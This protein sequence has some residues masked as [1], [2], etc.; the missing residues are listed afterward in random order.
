MK[1]KIGF[2]ICMI[3][4]V[5]SILYGITIWAAQSGTAFFMIWFV[6]AAL[7][8]II[9][10]AF[11]LGWIYVIK[12]FLPRQVR[13]SV[14]VIFL[15]LLGLF[16]SVEG[17][18][19]SHFDDHT[20]ENLDYLIVL[21]AK[22]DEHGPALS[23]RYRL[24]AASSYL[25]EHPYTVCILS[26]G[27]G[28]NEP[29]AEAVVMKEYLMNKGIEDSRM[30]VENQSLN[31]IGNIKNSWH[32]IETR[33]LVSGPQWKKEECKTGIVTN[34]FHL[35]RATQIGK[36]QMKGKIYGIAAP[37]PRGYLTNN[38]V[39]EFFGVVKDTLKNNM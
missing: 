15:L 35:Y 24:D 23:L 6:V 3:F 21:G 39:R 22:V 9:G 34:N 11:Y 37:T 20:E 25:E 30:I 38:M 19:F 28:M 36:K 14:V 13:A 12:D 33:G 17:V 1:N 26:G 31:T 4:T 7:F 16:V 2:V 5:C 32:L 27:K 29:E 18:I 8:A 10:F